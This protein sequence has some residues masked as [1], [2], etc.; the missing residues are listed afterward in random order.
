M[1]NNPLQQYFRQP[2]IFIG[3][4]SGGIY[5][6]PGTIQGDVNNMPIYGMTGMDEILLKTPDA[7]ISGE[8]TVRVI[9]SCCPSI[10]DGWDLSTLDANMI[11]AAIK[12]ATFGNVVTIGHT[13]PSC[14]AENDY[15]FDLNFVTDH[16]T[17]CKYNNKLEIG[18]MTIV[19]QPLSYKQSTDF[20]FKTFVLQQ[21]LGQVEALETEEEKTEF[22]KTLFAELAEIQN[23]LYFASVEQIQIPG[24]V[25]TE[26]L[27][28]LEFM[29]NCDKSVFDTIKQHIEDNRFAWTMP[30]HP[31]KCPECEFE[32]Q[33]LIELDQTN[34]FVN[35]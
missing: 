6:K 28:I 4:P 25:V 30:P 19:T 24:T 18:D 20:N 27:H 15:G 8:S 10:K 2:K 31:V 26:R 23:D 21:K 12:I 16:Y 14:G 33:V 17:K 11:F 29:K 9:E 7:L 32:S 34:F 22:Y 3:L 1:A 13:C 35:A 5:N